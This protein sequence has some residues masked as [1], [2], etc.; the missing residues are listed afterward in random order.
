MPTPEQTGRARQRLE[1]RSAELRAELRALDAERSAPPTSQQV[2]DVADS[3]DAGEQRSREAV[4]HAEQD[5]DTLELRAIAAALGR[6]EQGSYGTCIDCGNEIPWA[7]L[8]VQPAA[9]RDIG[10]QQRWEQTHPSELRA[11]MPAPTPRSAS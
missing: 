7:R 6:I 9:A 8:E 4:R 2:G 11:P 5:R 3:A 10:C 1:D